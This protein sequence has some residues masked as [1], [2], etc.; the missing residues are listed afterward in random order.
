MLPGKQCFRFAPT[1][2]AGQYML[3]L[4]KRRIR[5]DSARLCICSLWMCWLPFVHSNIWSSHVL[6]SWPPRIHCLSSSCLDLH[7]HTDKKLWHER[8]WVVS[9]QERTPS[10]THSLLGWHL[11]G[12]LDTRCIMRSWG[13]RKLNP[14]PAL[15]PS[16][17][18]F[19]VHMMVFVP[20]SPDTVVMAGFG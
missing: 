15:L 20:R 14:C 19:L 9:A 11:T 7:I 8:T 16:S 10:N 6:T 3:Q 2:K 12:I 4:G 1:I 17:F 5:A 13:G 18:V